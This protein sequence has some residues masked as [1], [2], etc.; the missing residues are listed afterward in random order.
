MKKFTLSG[1]IAILLF[2]TLQVNATNSKISVSAESTSTKVLNSNQNEMNLQFHFGDI[3]YFNVKTS[4]GIYTELRMKGAYST[5]RIG[6]PILP[7]QKKLIAI[8][9]GAELNVQ[10]NSFNVQTIEL[11][12]QGIKNALMPLQYDIP[13]DMDASDI[14]FQY[15]SEAYSAKSYNESEIAR[16]EILGVMRGVRIARVTVE[17]VRYNPS[18]N[19]LEVYNDI[20]IS[21]SYEN[22]DWAQTNQTFKSTYSPFYDIA[23]KALLNADNMYDDHPDLLTFPV[24]MLIVSHPMFTDALQP[25]IEWKTQMGYHLTVAY[26]DVIGSSTDEI[27]T[28]VHDQYNEGVANGNAPDLAGL[29]GFGLEVSETINPSNV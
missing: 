22:A 2:F 3:G 17:P 5:S 25:F 24:N 12:E 18:T 29:S 21:I 7:A 4:N 26:T 19:Q 8:P 9:F 1:F 28:W 27:K 6:E 16:V 20:D 15:K 10:V 23:Y 14:P 11:N 13:K